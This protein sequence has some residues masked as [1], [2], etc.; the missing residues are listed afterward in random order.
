MLY[1]NDVSFSFI[2]A[3]LSS[4]S[5]HFFSYLILILKA[6]THLFDPNQFYSH[7]SPLESTI[8]A[9]RVS[10]KVLFSS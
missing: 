8:E 10:Q 5:Q 4:A 9:I 2:G 1:I 7:I 6:I 3:T